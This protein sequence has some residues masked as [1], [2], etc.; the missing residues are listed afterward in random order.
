MTVRA[1]NGFS[2]TIPVA[3]HDLHNGTDYAYTG[4]IL[5]EME[6]I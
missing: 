4:S 2:T 5:R 3:R 6:S 1:D